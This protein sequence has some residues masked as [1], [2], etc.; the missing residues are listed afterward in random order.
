MINNVAC[1]NTPLPKACRGGDRCINLNHNK[2]AAT[3][4][5]DASG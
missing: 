5:K 2:I 3:G 1:L 4:L